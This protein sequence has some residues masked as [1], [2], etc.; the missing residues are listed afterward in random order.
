MTEPTW[1]QHLLMI[2][3]V[4]GIYLLIGIGKGWLMRAI[5]ITIAMAVILS[6]AYWHW[7]PN[8]YIPGIFGIALAWLL[9]VFPIMLWEWPIF[10]KS[11]PRPP[12]QQDLTPADPAER[13]A[14]LPPEMRET[15]PD[16]LAEMSLNAA[17]Q[18]SLPPSSTKEH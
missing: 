12:K 5:Q 8:P 3:A 11:R 10:E 13:W 16:R 2:G 18:R 9:T 17:R 6:N 15:D 14:H 4:I 7:T 1:W